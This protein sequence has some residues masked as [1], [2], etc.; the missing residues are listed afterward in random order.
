MI[1]RYAPA[2]AATLFSDE[3]RLTRWLEVELL[4]VEA[5]AMSGVAPDAAATAVRARAPKIDAAFVDAVA[6]RE[7]VTDH[8][9]AAFVDVVQERIGQPNGSWI[10]FGLTS[11]DVV[12][13]ALSVALVQAADL[14]IDAADGL[15]AA[16]SARARELRLVPV[17]GRTHGMHAEPTTFGA[18]FALWALQVDRDRQR[19]VSARR[20]VAVGKLSGAVG[21]YSNIDPEVEAFVCRAL[22]LDPVPATQV[23]A[24]DRHAEYLYACA[25]A[26][27]TIEL[28]ATEVRHLART[29]LGEVEEAFGAQQKGSSAMPHKRNPILSERLCGLARVLRGYLIAGLEDV[30]LWHERDISHSSVERIV[31]PDATA[32]TLYLLR[33]ATELVSGLVV[34]ADRAL[35]NLTTRSL[36]LVFSQSVLLAL[37]GAGFTRDEAYR[38]VQRDA[39]LAWESQRTLRAVLADDEELTLSEAVLDGAFDL[40]HLLRHAG[41]VVDALDDIDPK[42]P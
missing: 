37:V 32:L 5:L 36:G 26:G 1:P 17:A 29:E 6:E 16:L 42:G 30:A 19:L 34:H 15:I 22:G 28:I 7:R 2:D 20:R 38:I 10:H 13:T 4:T 3:S 18:K 39:R 21:T 25:A 31:I 41:R 8:D 40:D 27:S 11:S 35:D 14:L 12:D 23:I 24:R 33:K 9:V